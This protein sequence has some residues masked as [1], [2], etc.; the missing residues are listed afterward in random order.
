MN[1]LTILTYHSIDETGSVVSISPFLFDQH[2]AFL[3]E[4][5]FEVIRLKD[6]LEMLEQGKVGP[7]QIVLTFDDG[8]ENFHSRAFPVLKKYGFPST[9]FLV[10]D[11]CG[12]NNDW[13]GQGKIPIQPLMNW[14]QIEELSRD[15]V[16]FGSHSQTHPKLTAIPVHQA[17]K[18]ISDSQKVIEDR[19]GQAVRN[20][21]YP[22][23]N[24]NSRIRESVKKFYGASAGTN[25]AQTDTNDDLYN[26]SRVDVYYV[27]HRFH[28]LA[29]RSLARYLT[30]RNFARRL[31]QI[32]DA[33]GTEHK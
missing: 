15:G 19:I 33:D 1:K 14:S 13:P 23:G 27:A 17:E 20:F 3:N 5:G 30:I 4:N 7:K 31:K 11:Y 25:L 26:F 8:Y 12:R 29:K 24:S 21:A 22:Y 28:L 9:V 2:L 10:T 6:G 16:E 32:T 18:E